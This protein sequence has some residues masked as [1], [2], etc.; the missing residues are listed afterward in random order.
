VRDGGSWSEQ[1]E[2]NLNVQ[3]E[4]TLISLPLSH[5]LSQLAL[6]QATLRGQM[7]RLGGKLGE[8]RAAPMRALVET[9]AAPRHWGEPRIA[10][11]QKRGIALALR[12][13]ELE[14]GKLEQHAAKGESR[15]PWKRG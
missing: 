11:R 4:Y 2:L 15:E 10:A 9:W 7:K 3:G 12:K 8:A 5:T 13:V 6:E 1:L 14:L